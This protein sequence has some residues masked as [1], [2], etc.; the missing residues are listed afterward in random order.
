MDRTAELLKKVR[1][2]EL[3]TR[4]LTNHMF[5][6]GYHS[7]FKGKG[8][9]F[10]EV[11]EYQFGD[12]VRSIDWNVSA[13]LGDPFV[14]IF[15][16]ERELT[17]MLIVDMSGSTYF[18][19]HVGKDGV[20]RLKSDLIVEICAVLAFSAIKNND[21]V[22]MLLYSD[23]IER[24]IPP[25]KGRNHILF[26]IRELLSFQP[27]SKGSD[28]AQA[29]RYLSGVMKK[30]AIVFLL[31]DFMEDKTRTYEHALSISRR[32]HDLVGIRVFDEREATLPD[33]G[34]VRVADAESGAEQWLDTGSARIR[35][36]YANAY[37]QHVAETEALFLKTGTDLAS[38]RTNQ[39]YITALM[40]LFRMREKR[41]AI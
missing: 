36:S 12:D 19:A 41:M 32:R 15:E 6:G 35:A 33:A 18:G 5:A 14:K 37:R 34:L 27:Q 21:K 31:S 1:T 40:N 26:L 23:R 16:E 3:K 29:L 20:A 38:I 25:K 13:R 22:G 24:F 9:S 7:A 11:R 28:L 17:V 39:P 10:S 8:M 4:G 2:I 30:R